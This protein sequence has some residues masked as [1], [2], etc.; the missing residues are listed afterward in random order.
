MQ[1][2]SI[3]QIATHHRSVAAVDEPLDHPQQLVGRLAERLAD[4]EAML[5]SLELD[6]LDGL[7]H[8]LQPRPV[9]QHAVAEHVAQRRHDERRRKLHRREA[10]ALRP[11]RVGQRVV[12]ARPHRQRHAPELVG[13]GGR[14]GHARRRV[15]LRCRAIGPGEERGEQDVP[16][17]AHRGGG[18]FPRR[19]LD[20]DVVGQVG[21][22]RVAG[23]ERPGEVGR[24]REPRVGAGAKL[25]LAAQP[26]QE[27]RAV[28]DGRWE[29]VL[30]GEAVLHGQHDGRDLGCGAEAERVEV[31]LRER[32][33]A[34]AA[35]VEV[36]Q[37]RELAAA[38]H[39][40]R[41]PVH[42]D[43]KAVRRVVQ[44]VLPLH[45]GDVR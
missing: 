39:R 27:R 30:G 40:R 44:D 1:H 5:L 14:Q 3:R 34:V 43:T 11:E 22:R 32:A 19:D 15:G 45:A 17:D 25:G 37:H 29:A 26:G 12:H 35:A 10:R 41:R 24:L 9:P 21:T 4:G 28:V 38:G 18:D 42:A 7:P 8:V 20:R 13:H 31:G 2:A 33:E 36:H 16:D 23:E 6:N